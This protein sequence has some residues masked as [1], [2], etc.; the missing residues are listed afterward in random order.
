MSSE[1]AL[2]VNELRAGVTQGSAQGAAIVADEFGLRFLTALANVF[3]EG[4]VVLSKFVCD[5]LLLSH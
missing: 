4:A 5:L 3:I 1:G 2:L